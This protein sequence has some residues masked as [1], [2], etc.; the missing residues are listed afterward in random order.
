M[1]QNTEKNANWSA[2]EQFPNYTV[3]LVVST[4]IIIRPLKEMV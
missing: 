4:M 1:V 3:R 2:V